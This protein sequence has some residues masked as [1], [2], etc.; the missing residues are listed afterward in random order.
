MQAHPVHFHV[1]FPTRLTR[2]QLLVRLVA[3]VALGILGI[4]FG[5]V[6]LCAFFALPAFAAVRLG[7]RSANAYLADDGPRVAHALRWFAAVSA[8][9]GLLT[10]RLPARSAA[11]TADL[12]AT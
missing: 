10:D 7:A 12:S 11:A 4:S 6:F 9:V 2:L 3:F 1:P 8:W 5:T